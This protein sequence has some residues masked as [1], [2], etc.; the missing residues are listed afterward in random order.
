MKRCG[1][2]LPAPQ[3][4]SQHHRAPAVNQYSGDGWDGAGIRIRQQNHVDDVPVGVV[5]EDAVERHHAICLQA[6]RYA[7]DV[8]ACC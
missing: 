1:E 4:P 2:S 6:P 5:E 7:I 8:G 3:S